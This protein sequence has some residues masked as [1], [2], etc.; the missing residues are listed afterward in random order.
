M[1]YFLSGTFFQKY[2]QKCRGTT[3]GTF[4]FQVPSTGA[5]GTFNKVPSTGT[6]GTLKKYRAHLWL[7]WPSEESNCFRSCRLGYDSEFRETKDLEISIHS[8]S[9]RCSALKELYW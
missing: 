6:A 8:F 1:Q 2:R 3:G 9:I 5:V 7:R 4:N